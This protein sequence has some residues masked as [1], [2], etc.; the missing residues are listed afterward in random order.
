LENLRSLLKSAGAVEAEDALLERFTSVRLY[1]PRAAGLG[2][3]KKSVNRA[4]GG[5]SVEILKAELC[6]GDLS[7]EIEGIARM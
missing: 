4:F 3:L 2:E 7:V 1:A 5:A 6:R